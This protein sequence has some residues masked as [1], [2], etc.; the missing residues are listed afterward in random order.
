MHQQ[1]GHFVIS[2]DFEILW[3]VRDIVSLQ[4]YGEH[5]LGVQQVIPKTLTLFQ[6]YNINATFSTVGLLFFKNKQE[7]L[8]A[9]PKVLPT[10]NDNNLSPYGEYLEKQVG[11]SFE[12]D[13]YHFAPHL[14]ELIQNTPG[15]EIGTHTFSHY[16]SLEPGQNIESFKSDLEAAI[17]VANKAGVKITSIIFPRNQVNPSYLQVC[18][19]AGILAY[20]NNERSWIYE[21]TNGHGESLLRRAFRL[22]DTY[23]NFTGHHCY[24]FE[25]VK[26]LPVNIPSSRFLRPYWGLLGSFERLRMRRI[27]KAMTYAAKNK[28]MYHLWW[29]PH[30]FGINQDKNF[31]FL[32][33]ILAHY[34]ELNKIYGF[35]SITMTGL[36]NKILRHDTK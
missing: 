29:H 31:N 27:K 3:G 18:K 9:L 11:E 2:L 14:I 30:N 8:S 12:N 13:P 6:E 17:A 33:E 35:T 5:L 16:Y 23:V 32:K 20:R 26:N 25:E 22:A 19:D 21:A 7:M 15:Q 24:K 28:M 1:Q 10:Y 34:Q 4:S 36:A